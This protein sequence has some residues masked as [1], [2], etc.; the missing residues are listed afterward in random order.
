MRDARAA[1]RLRCGLP[2]GL[3]R[4]VKA[5]AALVALGVVACGSAEIVPESPGGRVDAADDAERQ[6][7]AEAERLPAG[8]KTTVAGMTVIA[9]EPYHAASGNTCRWLSISAGDGPGA[10]RLAC[11]DGAGWFFAPDVLG[12][13]IEVP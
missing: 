2:N 13:P 4:G 3:P 10:R 6:L 9:D 1:D 7:L 12:P 5:I 8:K 11:S